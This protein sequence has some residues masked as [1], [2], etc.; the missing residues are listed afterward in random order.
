MSFSLS[1]D[2]KSPIPVGKQLKTA[3]LTYIRQASLPDGTALPS[4]QRIAEAAQVSLRTADLA[5]QELVADGYCFR[6]PKRGTFVGARAVSQVKSLFGLWEAY[7]PDDHIIDLTYL[8]IQRSITELL[9]KSETETHMLLREPAKDIP[10]YTGISSFDFKGMLVYDNKLFHPMLELA[11]RFPK[12]KFV[13]LNYQM[14]GLEQTPDNVRAV[15]NDDFGGAYALLERYVAQGV[16]RLAVAAWPLSPSN[17]TY[18]ERLRG[19]QQAAADYGVQFSLDK[20]LIQCDTIQQGNLQTKLRNSYLAA[21][22][23]LQSGRR[24]QLIIALNDTIALA[25]QQCVEEEGLAG[26]IQIAGYDCIL[27]E[28]VRLHGIPSMRIQY[29]QMCQCGLNLLTQDFQDAPK[30]TLIPPVFQS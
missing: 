23:Y 1:I 8:L 9:T 14:E 6:R 25:F 20:D 29:P 10:F 27:S 18:K 26:Q 22:R 11:A 24:P 2:K 17:R 4:V 16:R 19:C 5:L 3:I 15:I 7:S 21:K 28:L 13:F 30:V 12:Q